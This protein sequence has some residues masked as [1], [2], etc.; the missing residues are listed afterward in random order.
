MRKIR[1]AQ[2]GTSLYSHGEGIFKTIH[3]LSDV[4]E[5]VGYALPEKE[6]EKFPE[7]MKAFGDYPELTVEQTAE[8]IIAL[9][10]KAM[11]GKLPR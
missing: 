10:E 1:I 2:I 9:A 7:R 4:F 3:R 6:R 5:I 11:G 8:A